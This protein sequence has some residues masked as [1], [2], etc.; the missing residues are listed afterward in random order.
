MAHFVI[1]DQT[2]AASIGEGLTFETSNDAVNGIIDLSK[3]D[4][5]LAA[6]RR[7]NGCFI[8]KIGQVCT[9]E[10]RS[11]A[12]NAVEGQL[13]SKLLV[14]RM[15][16]KNGQTSLDVWGID[17]DLTVKSAGTHQG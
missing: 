4:G 16:L 1:R 11:P 17:R 14:A 8:E 10:T 5:V 3:A 7:E 13:R 6:P 12:G 2:L 9:C 15:H